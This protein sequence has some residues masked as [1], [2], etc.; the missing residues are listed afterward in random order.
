MLGFGTQAI[1][2]DNNGYLDLIVTNGHVEKAI[3]ITDPFEQPAQLFC[4]VGGRFELVSVEDESGYWAGNHLGRGLSTL[5]FNRDGRMDAVIT[6]MGEPSALLQ[7]LSPRTNHW[8]QIELVGVNSERDA[9]GAKIEV[10]AG[11]KTYTDWRTAG[12][13]FFACNEAIV[14]F[15]LGSNEIADE[16]VIHWPS[17]HRQSLKNVNGN[18]RILLVENEPGMVEVQ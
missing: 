9:I 2:Y 17:G 3:S 10:R 12:D 18:Q 15:G 1:D 16:I 5:D 6:H 11:G 7:N 8:L 4:N 13:G 14:A